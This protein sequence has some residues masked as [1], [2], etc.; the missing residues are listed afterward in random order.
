MIQPFT[1]SFLPREKRTHVQTQTCRRIFTATLFLIFPNGNKQILIS[2]WT[3]KNKMWCIHTVEILRRIETK[4]PEETFEVMDGYVLCV[5]WVIA[6][7]QVY[8]YIK[9]YQI[10]YVK[11]VQFTEC[12]SYLNKVTKMLHS[13]KGCISGKTFSSL[14]IWILDNW[15]HYLHLSSPTEKVKI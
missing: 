11:Y 3:D 6:V 15:I 2:R 10:V 14:I 13:P 8:V 5:A 1:S 12:Q 7:A 4:G 9:T